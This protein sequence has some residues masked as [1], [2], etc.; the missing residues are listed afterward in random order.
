[1]ACKQLQLALRITDNG[2]GMATVRRPARRHY[3]IAA[4]ATDGSGTRAE[5]SVRVI[6]PVKNF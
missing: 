3:K 6:V 5:M 2:N 4:I 1:M